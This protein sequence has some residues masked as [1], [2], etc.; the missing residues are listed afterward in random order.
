MSA[1][2]RPWPPAD[3]AARTPHVISL[4]AG[5]ILH[6][7]Y[8]AA[9]EPIH[10]DRSLNGRLNAPD[11]SYGVLYAAERPE[12]A[13]AETFLRVPGR[14]QLPADLRERKG[15]VRLRLGRDL[16][17]VQLHGPGLAVL[18]ATAE[19]TSGGLPYGLP[20]AWSSAIH[21]HPGTF[22]GIAYR[23]RHDDNE[24]CFAIFGRASDAV[25]ELDR[26]RDLDQDWFYELMDVYGLGLPP[27]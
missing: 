9:L 23:A 18:G 17:L 15:Y 2:P 27:A 20:Q 5:A 25:E 6:R 22:E 3:L 12:G 7:F 21:H 16:N 26:G 24:I 11:A 14:T 19:V 4:P 13:F 1:D 8:T 10:F